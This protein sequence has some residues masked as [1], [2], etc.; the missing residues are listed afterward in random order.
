MVSRFSTV[1]TKLAIALTILLSF[2]I[3]SS[4]QAKDDCQTWKHRGYPVEMGVCSYPNGG[5][6]YTFI[7]NNGNQAATICWT[8]VA[9]NG[10]RQ[11]GCHS[12][13][14]AGETARSS[15]YQC[16]KKNGGCSQILLKSYEVNR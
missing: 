14:G 7:T 13:M 15:A 1:A 2:G 6:G 9:N 3:V 10:N 4:A 8:V 11:Q 16:G 12:R 5:S